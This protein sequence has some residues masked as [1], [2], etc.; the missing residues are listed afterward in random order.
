VFQQRTLSLLA[1]VVR[2]LTLVLVVA[3]AVIYHQHFH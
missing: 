1:V 2:D 3:V